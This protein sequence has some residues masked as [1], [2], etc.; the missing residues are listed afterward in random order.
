MGRELELK[1]RD[2]KADLSLRSEI[3]GMKAMNGM[4][5]NLFN[6]FE[7]SSC[8][9]GINERGPTISLKMKLNVF[10]LSLAAN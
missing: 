6:L 9:N 10:S 1:G 8:G 4:K 3:N 5:I 7:W 2:E